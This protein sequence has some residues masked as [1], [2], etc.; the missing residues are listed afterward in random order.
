MK[1]GVGRE[2]TKLGCGA[3]GLQRL[4]DP[5]GNLSTAASVPV[6][7]REKTPFPPRLAAMFINKTNGHFLTLNPIW[8]L[9]AQLFAGFQTPPCPCE[10][11]VPTLGFCALP[12][13]P[14]KGPA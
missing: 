11:A 5:A 10:G 9:L 8:H 12:T 4:S 13:S 2:G 7:A 1:E 14:G 6:G 3:P